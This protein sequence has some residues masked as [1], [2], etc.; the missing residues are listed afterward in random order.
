MQ[1]KESQGES[2]SSYV[3]SNSS[4]GLESSSCQSRMCGGNDSLLRRDFSWGIHEC[5]PFYTCK[6]H[7]G[8]EEKS[9]QQKTC[10][11]NCSRLPIPESETL[12]NGA[13][14][15]WRKHR[16]TKRYTK[17]SRTSSHNKDAPKHYGA[18]HQKDYI[19]AA[20]PQHGQQFLFPGSRAMH[21]HT[22]A[23]PIGFFRAPAFS[24][25]ASLPLYPSE[26]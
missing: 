1:R 25:A 15:G 26:Q 24:A 6:T 12:E 11:Q 13:T 22:P 18:E 17:T 2:Y 19:P 20:T 14:I 5:H 7:H 10:L 4:P 8:K 9:G 21:T 3:H 16:R 23:P